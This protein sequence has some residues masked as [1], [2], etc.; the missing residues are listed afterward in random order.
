M[1]SSEQSQSLGDWQVARSA[2][3]SSNGEDRCGRSRQLWQQARGTVIGL[4]ACIQGASSKVR[5]RSTCPSSSPRELIIN[6]KTAKTLNLDIPP[7][8]LAHANEVIE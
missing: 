2:C 3:R 5:N 8:L 1:T 6:L 4:Q 7:T